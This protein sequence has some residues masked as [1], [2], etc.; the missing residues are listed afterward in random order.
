MLHVIHVNHQEVQGEM[1]CVS[2]EFSVIFK[3]LFPVLERKTSEVTLL[4]PEKQQWT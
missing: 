1:T 3:T 4:L 2:S